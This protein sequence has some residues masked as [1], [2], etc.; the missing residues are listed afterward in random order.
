MGERLE[1]TVDEAQRAEDRP[2]DALDF[3]GPRDGEGLSVLADERTIDG[4]V[5]LHEVAA[6]SMDDDGPL[7]DRRRVAV[8]G[9]GALSGF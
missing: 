4:H 1:P 5:A 3:G 2:A 8:G 6:G 9:V 7:C